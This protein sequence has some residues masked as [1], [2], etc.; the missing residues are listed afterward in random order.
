MMEAK[1]LLDAGRLSEAIE[2]LTREVKAHP[3][4]ATRRMFLFELL[5]FAGEWERALKH[6]DVAAGGD[7]QTEVGAQVYRNNVRAMRERERLWDEGVAPNFLSEPTRDVQLH[8]AAVAEWRAGGAARAAELLDEA[9]DLR[10]PLTGRVDGREFS[11]WR[12]ADDFL[13]PVLELIIS[14]KYTWLPY[15]EVRRVE[16]A[17]PKRLRDMVWCQARVETR[18]GVSGEMFVPALYEGSGR[19]ADDEVRLG[20]VTQWEGGG[21]EGPERAA[22]LRLFVAGDEELAISEVRRIEFD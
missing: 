7:A 11:G 3:T 4:D 17:P 12:D 16:L 20:R 5:L 22:G 1:G 19:H 15:A 8:L 10:G 13:A 2:S 21:E 18:R 6:L 14:D 9:E